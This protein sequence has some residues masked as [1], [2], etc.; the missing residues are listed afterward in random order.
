MLFKQNS[1]VR[2][3]FYGKVTYNYCFYKIKYISMKLHDVKVNKLQSGNFEQKDSSIKG[4]FV[5]YSL[6]TSRVPGQR[7]WYES[8]D[9]A[10]N[11]AISVDKCDEEI[12]KNQELDKTKNQYQIKEMHVLYV[13][14]GDIVHG[15]LQ[16]NKNLTRLTSIVY[17]GH[18]SYFQ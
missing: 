1:S 16:D 10:R 18:T 2:I 9:Q 12:D 15:Y 6:S 5:G 14:H 7:M 17:T 3:C 11:T 4:D 8:I 13:K